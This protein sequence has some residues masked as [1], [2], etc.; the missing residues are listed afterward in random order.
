MVDKHTEEPNMVLK[1]DSKDKEYIILNTNAPI[2]DVDNVKEDTV[3]VNKNNDKKDGYNKVN[4]TKTVEDKDNKDKD[5][6]KD[7]EKE[8]E[9]E[10]EAIEDV[11]RN[12]DCADE[13]L[14]V[15]NFL[16]KN[17]EQKRLIMARDNVISWKKWIHLVIFVY[18]LI[19][20]IFQMLI[21]ASGTAWVLCFYVIPL[22]LIIWSFIEYWARSE[23]W[24][25]CLCR[26]IIL[27][28]E[29]TNEFGKWACTLPLYFVY[30]FFTVVAV[31]WALTYK[32]E[33][34]EKT[35]ESKSEMRYVGAALFL[36]GILFILVMTKAFVDIEGAPR[37]LSVNM[38]IFLLDDAKV[39]S[40]R[41][42]KV[43]HYSQL[44]KYFNSRDSNA[45][46]SWNDLYKLSHK[47]AADGITKWNLTWGF[48]L[49]S[50]LR[51]NK[52]V[53]S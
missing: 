1:D 32:P 17:G 9:I 11:I 43:V 35:G 48:S 14:S 27:N 46:F 51:D 4:S 7:K 20:P 53:R 8:K 22:A 36:I 15:E 26:G 38:F 16:A 44:D 42:Y 23:I 31:I 13:E 29:K 2:N 47:P 39:L 34:D 33:K 10:E 40:S 41:G 45:K 5:N 21:S 6:E 30:F 12:G 49:A 28:M 25:C 19:S 24:Y 50:L 37:L 3:H 18:L 52:D